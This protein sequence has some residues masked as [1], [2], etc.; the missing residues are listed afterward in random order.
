MRS[1]WGMSVAAA[2]IATAGIPV[3]IGIVML[4]DLSPALPLALA[5]A[6]AGAAAMLL[7]R[8]LARACFLVFLFALPFDV[9]KGVLPPDVVNYYPGFWISLSDVFLYGF[10]ALWFFGRKLIGRERYRSNDLV[11]FALIYTGYLWLSA[12]LA[13]DVWHGIVMAVTHTKYLVAFLAISDFVRK[14]SDLRAPAYAFSIGLALQL[15]MIGAQLV[16]RS[17]LQFRGT[18]LADTGNLTFSGGFQAF[19]PTGFLKHPIALADYLVFLLLPAAGLLLAGPRVIGGRWFPLLLLTAGGAFAL[20]ATLSRGGWI[21]F[22]IAMG[23]LFVLAAWRR[24]IRRQWLGGAA[25]ALVVLL[26]VTAIVYPAAYLRLVDSDARS[27]E[28]R[29]LMIDQAV[30]IGGENPVLGVGL[31]GYHRAARVTR[32]A[33]FGSANE[34]LR[35][36]LITHLGVVHNKYLL[37]YAE[38]GLVGVALLLALLWKSV[39][40]FFGVRRWYDRQQEL[41]A[42]GLAGALVA[43]A[44]LYLFDHFYQEV[45][46]M[47]FWVFAGL[48]AALTRAQ[49][50]PASAGSVRP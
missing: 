37:V 25:V 21:A 30:M 29:V 49:P 41:V 16:T 2:G 33:S 12:C 23:F 31:G 46:L 9:A 1:V 47:L 19:R 10:L 18:N 27:S 13:V 6:L 24:L 11:P 4:S 42:L 45:G 28:G 43:Q 22:A 3:A 7:T 32:P 26:A 38:H 17:Y 34:V 44:V 50:S 14:P 36:A 8:D 5:L 40:L 35:E 48:L 20:V 39:R 15:S